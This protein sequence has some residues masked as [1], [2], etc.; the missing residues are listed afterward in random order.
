MKTFLK[1]GFQTF[2]K[3]SEQGKRLPLPLLRPAVLTTGIRKYSW[4][5]PFVLSF[6]PSFFAKS[7]PPEARVLPDKSQFIDI[8][9]KQE[10][11]PAFFLFA[12]NRHHNKIIRVDL[13]YFVSDGAL[14]VA[15]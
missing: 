12:V 4:Q 14:E 7:L 9:R 11:T 15:I 1:K 3:P 10:K 5:K 2:Q 6:L 13:A 8:K